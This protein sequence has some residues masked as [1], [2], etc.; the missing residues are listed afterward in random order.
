MA[1]CAVADL[2]GMV[3][4]RSQAITQNEGCHTVS[5]EPIGYL[6][7]L[8][9]HRQVPVPAAGTDDDGPATGFFGP[10]FVQPDAG[11][12]R[13]VL[14]LSTGAPSD[15]SMIC[16][17]SSADDAGVVSTSSDR[18]KVPLTA[19]RSNDAMLCPF[20]RLTAGR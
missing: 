7:P 19:Q 2:R 8:V 1:R 20:R 11:L 4:F 16:G 6:V 3:V 12:V 17:G 14:P 9:R 15:H 10:R 18:P 13:V 5:V